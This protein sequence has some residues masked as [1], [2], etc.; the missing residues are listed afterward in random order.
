[1][2]DWSLLFGEV[3]LNAC[4]I[5][6]ALWFAAWAGSRLLDSTPGVRGALC[7]A[8]LA[9][10]AALPALQRLEWP[11]V[12]PAYAP[13]EAPAPLPAVLP[14]FEPGAAPAP[15]QSDWRIPASPVAEALVRL[16]LLG[17]ACGLAYLGFGVLKALRLKARAASPRGE[18]IGR[19][20]RWTSFASPRARLLLSADIDAPVAVG[21]LRPAVLFPDA[22]ADALDDHELERL[23]LHEAAHLERY[24]D[25]QILPEKTCLALLW[26]HPAAW[27]L[28]RRVAAER[29]MACDDLAADRAGSRTDYAR[30]LTR[31][32][33]LRLSRGVAPVLSIAGESNLSRRIEMLLRDRPGSSR[34][35]RSGLAFAA[36]L[37][38][39]AI[40]AVLTIGP[41]IGLAQVAPP[42]PAVPAAPAAPA[43]PPSPPSVPSPASPRSPLAPPA[44]PPVP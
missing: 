28:A 10:S 39:S 24:D 9:A 43:A 11:K 33:G 44:V 13:L 19:A 35:G 29:E 25:W 18:W 38:G 31:L 17:A 36:A 34:L 14:A 6:A 7:L 26:F 5:G 4:W 3:L 8:A 30:T 1:M 32:A 22:L 2:S 23:W 40:G 42:A 16:W 37:C 41:L 27:A 15:I 12:H 21:W 20:E